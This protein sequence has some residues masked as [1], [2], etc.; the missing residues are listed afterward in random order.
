MFVLTLLQQLKNW[1]YF[2]MRRGIKFIIFV[3][4]MAISVYLTNHKD[5]G[6]IEANKNADAVYGTMSDSVR[7]KGVVLEP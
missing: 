7:M 5:S 1:G 3:V 4:L 2:K 6:E